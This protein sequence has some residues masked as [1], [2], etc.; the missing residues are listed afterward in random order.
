[1]CRYQTSSRFKLASIQCTSV[2][3]LCFRAARSARGA[4]YITY[5]T[6]SAHPSL[7]KREPSAWAHRTQRHV[8]AQRIHAVGCTGN[9]RSL[10]ACAAVA[11]WTRRAGHSWVVLL[12][13][14]GSFGAAQRAYRSGGG[15]RAVQQPDRLAES[16]V[17]LDRKANSTIAVHRVQDG[18]HETER[19]QPY[20]A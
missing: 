11:R 6:A 20:S 16:T 13:G 15:R 19:V 12:G 9:V 10:V 18:T 4:R 17:H 2:L 3:R 1:M 14:G 5:I 7:A 8:L